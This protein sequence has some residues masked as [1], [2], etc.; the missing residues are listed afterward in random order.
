MKKLII[1]LLITLI[2]FSSAVPVFAS[3]SIQNSPDNTY[4]YWLGYDDKNLVPAKPIYE[5][6]KTI[7]GNDIGY[8]GVNFVPTDIFCAEDG[9]IYI[10]E[11]DTSRV[12]I[13]DKN[14]SQISNFTAV[15]K[16]GESIMFDGA[17]GIF[18]H[19][20][21]RVFIADT[22]HAK[23]LICNSNGEYISELDLPKSKII[24]KDF[25]FYPSKVTVDKEGYIYV[26]SKGSTYGALLYNSKYGFEGFYGANTTKTTIGGFFSQIWN[27]FVM[28]DEMLSGQIKSIPYQF[29]DFCA[30]SEGFIY[31]VTGNTS[32]TEQTGQIK[33]LGP[34]A[35][36]LLRVK[37]T[38]KYKNSNDF[39]FSDTNSS[40]VH[41]VNVDFNGIA[42]DEDGYIYAL[43]STYGRIFVYDK[44]C[45]L[46]SAFGG[47]FGEG[48][49]KG[50]FSLAGSI[51]AKN[52]KV[53]VVDQNLGTIT[54]FGETKYGALVKSADAHYLSG[55]YEEGYD[56][57][58]KTLSLDRNSQVA[59]RGLAKSCIIKGDYKKA[60]YYAKCG[61]D[62][63]SYSQ[64]LEMTRSDYLN[65][66]L[67]WIVLIIVFVI[68]AIIFVPLMLKKKNKKLITNKKVIC[69]LSSSVHPFD[70]SYLIA[71]E[72]MG[73][74]PLAVICL[75]LFFIAKVLQDT[76]S[77]FLFS[78]FNAET[79]NSVMTLIGS[80]GVVLLW[81]VCSWAISVLFEGKCRLKQTFVIASY[82]MIPQIINSILFLIFSQFLTSDEAVLI[83][84]I[85]VLSLILSGIVIVIGNMTIN[86]FNFFKFLGTA[87]VTL[88]AMFVCIFVIFMVAILMQQLFTFF[89]TVMSEVMYR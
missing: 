59:Y 30:D 40:T 77:G 6:S 16:N 82:A 53:F 58:K 15:T 79:Y 47:G 4:S 64:A 41:L 57:F 42:V 25:E 5:V 3:E 34:S 11:A 7:I 71:K 60:L 85:S 44:E 81:S 20:D 76:K 67:W 38:D 35:T 89:A 86:E 83:S 50:V 54:V 74:V 45:N 17:T 37:Q 65:S 8:N 87:I 52:G 1:A 70:A 88:V 31:T 39:N 2:A 56:L 43:D 73:S 72:N 66:N 23:V 12:T 46:L 24:P 22:N 61:I 28:T 84:I 33:C 14:Y 51:D 78:R 10:L 48:K 21:G 19:K 9:K 62:Y 69:M 18:V 68:F 26:L 29:T 80:V 55:D 63:E 75:V 36:N 49:Q 32:E 13:L 27:N